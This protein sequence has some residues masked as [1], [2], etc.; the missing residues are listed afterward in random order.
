MSVVP[1]DYRLA[2]FKLLLPLQ[3]NTRALIIDAEE[4]RFLPHLVDELGEIHSVGI[5]GSPPSGP[6]PISGGNTNVQRLV[7]PLGLY[8]LVFSDSLEAAQ[9]LRPGGTLCHLGYDSRDTR[10]PTAAGLKPIGR[11]RA[12]PSWPDFRVLIPERAAGWKAAIRG[13]RLLPV[14]S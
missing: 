9:Y 13:L 11:W 6:Q 5:E 14:R 12:F 10:T 4:I 3:Q 7:R 8:D 1:N 2:D